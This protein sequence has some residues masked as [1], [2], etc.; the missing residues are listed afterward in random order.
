[1][2]QLHIGFNANFRNCD[3]DAKLFFRCDTAADLRAAKNAI[4][5]YLDKEIVEAE[6][7]EKEGEG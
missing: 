6:Q 7:Q 2:K 3:W 5:G 4:C 1:M